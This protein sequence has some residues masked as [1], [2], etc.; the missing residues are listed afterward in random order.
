MLVYSNQHD[1]AKRYK[2]RRY[3]LPKGVMKDYN[4]IIMERTLITNQSITI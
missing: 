4:V 3:Y 1:N 2:N